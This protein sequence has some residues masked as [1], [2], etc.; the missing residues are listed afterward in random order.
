M[1]KFNLPGLYEHFKLNSL[2]INLYNEKRE[3]FYDNISIGS[4]FGNFPFCIWDGGRNF[5][6]YE[7]ATKEKIQEVCG[8]YAQ[9]N[10]APRLVFT[11]PIIQ[12]SD[13]DDRYGN[14]VL[15]TV[16]QYKGEVVI[17]SDL[18]KNYI[19]AN[20]PKLKLVSSTTKRLVN[21]EKALEEIQNKEFYQICLDYDLNKNLNFLNTIPFEYRHKIEFLSNA[22]CPPHCPFRKQ[23]YSET[24]LSHLTYLKHKY[25]VTPYCGITDGINHP[26]K[27]GQ[28]NNLSL[29]D[30]QKY[31]EMGYQYFKLEGRTLRSGSIIGNY[32]YY[33]IKPEWHYW[34]IET[35]DQE[36]IL[37]NNY[38]SPFVYN[39]IQKKDY[40]SMGY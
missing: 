22:I 40:Y 1:I 34:F 6:F 14:I 30:I 9:N 8:F 13:L 20:Y 17:N 31:N 12:E 33:L 19:Q 23:H 38:N 36:D 29:E 28:G 10:V 18:M 27:L 3:I 5:M 37:I 35:I 24:G 16:E 26:N 11:N 2:I 15:S 25:T 21:P 7:Q 39:D 32:L 4:V